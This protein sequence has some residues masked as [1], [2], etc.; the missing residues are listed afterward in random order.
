MRS[1][2]TFISKLQYQYYMATYYSLG[3]VKLDN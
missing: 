1:N 3:S 2:E